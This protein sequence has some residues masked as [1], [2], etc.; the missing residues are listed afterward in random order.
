M[1]KQAIRGSFKCY[2]NIGKEKSNFDHIEEVNEDIVNLDS[3][4][5]MKLQALN[6]E[7][8]YDAKIKEKID[9]GKA[10]ILGKRV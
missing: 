10:R 4:I 3:L 2:I 9:V 5:N 7:M 8:G 6:E 1:V